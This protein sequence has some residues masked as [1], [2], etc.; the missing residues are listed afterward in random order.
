MAPLSPEDP[1]SL[2]VLKTLG[3]IRIMCRLTSEGLR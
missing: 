2:T 1:Y 3:S